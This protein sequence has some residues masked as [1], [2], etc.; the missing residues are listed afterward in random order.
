M[1]G[2]PRD[3]FPRSM[4]GW[5]PEGSEARGSVLAQR[6]WVWVS[7]ALCSPLG[8]LGETG[9]PLQAR[10]V[11]RSRRL[12]ARPEVDMGRV[13]ASKSRQGCPVNFQEKM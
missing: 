3:P 11:P 7:P 5:G 4:G 2:V 6:W 9:S 1:E 8:L 13:P 10:K 12:C